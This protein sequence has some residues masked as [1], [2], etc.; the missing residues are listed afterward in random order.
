MKALKL[1]LNRLGKIL[2]SGLFPNNPSSMTFTQ[3]P[4]PVNIDGTTRIFFST[5]SQIDS[6]NNYCSYIHFVDY[7]IENR[8][9]LRSSLMP[10]GLL[11]TLSDHEVRDL[12]EFLVSGS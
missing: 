12:L 11:D 9:E 6:D 3:A 7:D 8:K 5:R 1:K 10:S 4:F 2:D